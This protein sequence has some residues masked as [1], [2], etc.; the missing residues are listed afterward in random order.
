MSMRTLIDTD[1]GTDDMLAL[2]LLFSIVPPSQIDIAVSF[3]NVPLER[4]M[5][6]VGLFTRLRGLAPH[7]QLRGAGRPLYGEPYKATDVHGADGLGGVVMQ[8]AYPD[9]S[10]PEAVDLASLLR[11][12]SYRR[13]ISIGPLTDLRLV[14]IQGTPAPLMVMGGAFDHPGNMSPYAEFNIFCDAEAAAEVFAGWPTEIHVVPLDLTHQVVLERKWLDEMSRR[15]PSPVAAFLRD[16]HQHYMDV[17]GGREGIDGC[18]PH[19]ALAVFACFF[20]EAV[21]WRR[22]RVHV[23]TDGE[24]RA[25]TVL[26]PD[27]AGPHFVAR[28]LDQ[29][30]FFETVE[31]A[32]AAAR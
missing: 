2:F 1:A 32:F 14:A 28:S 24:Q 8:G 15:H 26:T 11:D 27:A 7:R 17:Y 20:P 22:G 18:H 12:S 25:R 6:N 21:E 30:R 10:D 29:K 16:A 19:D 23:V 13:M 31:R 4:A 5:R 9:E 3:G